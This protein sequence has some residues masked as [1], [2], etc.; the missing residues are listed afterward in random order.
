[1]EFLLHSKTPT[2]AKE[3]GYVHK[4]YSDIYMGV[5]SH[6][7]IVPDSVCHDVDSQ[8][9]GAKKPSRKIQKI[10]QMKRR[11]QFTAKRHKKCFVA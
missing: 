7:Q 2:S 6:T 3:V 8:T 11:M 9:K 10:K 1:M 4:T 5:Q